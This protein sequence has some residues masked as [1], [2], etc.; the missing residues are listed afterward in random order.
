K[1]F[2]KLGN[3]SDVLFALA[4]ETTP[5][6]ANPNPY[7]HLTG[8]TSAVGSLNSRDYVFDRGYSSLKGPDYA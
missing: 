6:A 7:L 3:R 1:Y 4:A 2:N 8:A 5:G